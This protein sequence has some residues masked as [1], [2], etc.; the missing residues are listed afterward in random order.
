MLLLRNILDFYCFVFIDLIIDVYMKFFFIIKKYLY[1]VGKIYI[2]FFLYYL[3]KGDCKYI[4]IE[5][6]DFIIIIIN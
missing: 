2:I 5:K 1:R 4:F 6:G 3:N